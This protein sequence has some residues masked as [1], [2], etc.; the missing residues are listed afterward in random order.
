MRITRICPGKESLEISFSNMPRYRISRLA[1]S[2][3]SWYAGE[4]V[5]ANGY[6]GLRYRPLPQAQG[7]E[8]YVLARPCSVIV[9]GISV[10]AFEEA[11]HPNL[12]D[13]LQG[14]RT[15]Q[16]L[17]R[18]EALSTRPEGHESDLAVSAIIR[19]AGIFL[20]SNAD[21]ID[22][23]STRPDRLSVEIITQDRS[24]P[25]FNKII[26]GLTSTEFTPRLLMTKT[27]GHRGYRT[28]FRVEGSA[29]EI[30]LRIQTL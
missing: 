28:T 14:A 5:L 1:N 9:R 20:A 4:Q 6:P 21:S 18:V 30:D 15:E 25:T 16:Y 27:E 24:E 10:A 13:E 22:L 8:F 17:H 11:C 12:N 26:S 19:R 29:T 3:P 7:I 2:L 23:W